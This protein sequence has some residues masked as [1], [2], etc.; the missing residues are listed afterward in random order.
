MLPHDDICELA[1]L[2]IDRS[3]RAALA[4]ALQCDARDIGSA[5]RA[6]LTL[7]Q[8]PGAAQQRQR[9]N[10]GAL[11]ILCIGDARYPALL[12]ATPDPPPILF[13]R[14]D[15]ELLAR[16][17]VAIV[18]SRKA[19]PSSLT[20]AKEIASDLSRLGIVVVS[21]LARGVDGVA[22][23]GA[24]DATSQR[25]IEP[26]ETGRTIAVLGAGLDRIYPAEHAGLFAR[27]A[28][29]GLL[30]T[31]YGPGVRPYPSHFPQRN[32]I[33]SGLARAVVVIEAG[34]QSGS[35][36]TAREALEQ[37]REV[38]VVPGPVQGGRFAG[39]HR[40][41][42]DGAVLVESASDVLEAVGIAAIEH[43][44]AVPSVSN[45]DAALQIT[46]DAARV[47]D[48]CAIDGPGSGVEAISANVGMSIAVV[49]QLLA[50][51]EIDGFVAHSL[52]GY[53]RCR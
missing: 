4:Q 26:A 32:R 12:S 6:L 21:G 24:L 30:L 29:H 51:L 28:A 27:V 13:C 25:A 39:S 8:K 43:P 40:L 15:Q 49:R 35:L 53:V 42:R 20:L 52:H 1:A 17:C 2:A 5:L 41:L 36:G 16:P 3:R 9:T 23:A 33:I 31:E 37:G 48:C 38:L 10:R 19:L 14:G 45:T 47:L 44:A 22:H 7:W 18:G 11:D 34:A 46:T 50:E